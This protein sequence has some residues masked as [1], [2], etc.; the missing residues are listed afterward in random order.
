MKQSTLW[1]IVCAV[2]L[3]A[4]GYYFLGRADEPAEPLTLQSDGVTVDDGLLIKKKT[5]DYQAIIKEALAQKAS[6][7]TTTVSRD[8]VRDRRLEKAIKYTPFPASTAR[9]RVKYH[10]EYPIGYVL[11]PGTFKVSGGEDGLVMTLHRPRLIARPSV[12]LLSYDILEGGIL[13]DEKV[14]L[15]E[16]Q[17]LIQPQAER[18]AKAVLERPAILPAS[19]RALRGFLQPFLR[20]QSGGAPPPPITFQ[21]R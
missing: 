2:A 7:L 6:F 5:I 17:Q 4:A 11:S 14:A 12:K 9:V 20:N 19:E 15:L 18:S 16:L 8:V 21:Y 3:A 13:I 10:V 1:A